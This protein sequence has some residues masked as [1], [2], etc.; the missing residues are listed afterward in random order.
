MEKTLSLLLI[1]GLGLVLQSKVKNPEQLKGVK[2]L[3][4]SVALPAT[5]FSALLE[6]RIDLDLLLLPILGLLI[7]VMLIGVFYLTFRFLIPIHSSRKR[8]LLMLMPSLA[9]GLS[10]FPFISEYLGSDYLAMAALADVGNKIFVLIILYMLAM[11]W[12]YKRN[13]SVDT[14]N[15][16]RMKELVMSLVKEPINM[17]IVLAFLL[18]ALGVNMNTLPSAISSLVIRLSTMMAP[19]VLLFIGMAVKIKKNDVGLI[20]RM[21]SLRS[22]LAFF[23]SALLMVTI[24]GLTTPTILLLFV[25][26][27]SSASFWPYAHISMVSM[28]EK[29]QEKKT[30]DSDLA[31]SILALS[32]PFSTFIILGVLSFP[33]VAIT[34][35]YPIG[36]GIILTLIF[37]Y[38][39][40]KEKVKSIM[41]SK[42]QGFD[43]TQNATGSTLVER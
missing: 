19:L 12:F 38:K 11:H 28:M 24:P 17:V 32:L 41:A 2:V 35:I 27:Q 10:C 3:I 37:L 26:A 4:L 43:I 23:L 7:N 5:I 36:I 29:D 15:G 42:E 20:L 1:I 31:L 14:N 30:F 6:V 25:F 18:L 39:P 22:G 21:L 40:T 13:Q 9:P 34:P 33:V 16:G 8:T